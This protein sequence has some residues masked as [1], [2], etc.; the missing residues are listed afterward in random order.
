MSNYRVRPIEGPFAQYELTETETD[1][2][3]VIAAGRGG[4]AIRFRSHGKELFYLDEA[5][6]YD[7]QANVRGGNPVLFPI[8]GQLAEGAYEWNGVRYTMKNHGVARILPWKVLETNDREEASITLALEA[9]A[10]TLTAYPFDFKLQFTYV[11]KDGRLTIRQQYANRSEQPMPMYAGFHPYFRTEAKR[12]AYET[13]ATRL[14]DY[15][16]NKEKPFDGSVDLDE[17][18]EAS[19][20]LDAASGYIRFRPFDDYSV[21]VRYDALFR[22][23]VLWSVKDKP[24]VCVEPWMARTRALNEREELVMVG[25]G[26]TLHAEI[27]MEGEPL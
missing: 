3:V 4:M 9:D 2:L 21:C 17:G 18:P 20:L 27:S 14:Y 19:A 13:D 16:D 23:V 11:L 1:S 22:Y 12:L 7:E 10:R 5:T 26:Q 8:C 24:F 25:P 6:F 15:N